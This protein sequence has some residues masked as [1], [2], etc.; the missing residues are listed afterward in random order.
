MFGAADLVLIAL[1]FQ[2]AYWTRSQLNLENEFFLDRPVAILLLVWSML[3]WVGLAAWWEIY[4][5]I[6]ATHPRVIL[7]DAFRQC[8]LGAV[9]VVLFDFLWTRLDG[10]ERIY[11][12]RAELTALRRRTTSGEWALDP[13]TVHNMSLAPKEGW[14]YLIGWFEAPWMLAETEYFTRWVSDSLQTNP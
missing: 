7:R 10:V 2:L 9:A 11:V 14:A 12:G 1:G 8:L 5:R 13:F 6:D 3:V 4:D